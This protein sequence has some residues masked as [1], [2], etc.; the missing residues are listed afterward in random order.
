[1]SKKNYIDGVS[2]VIITYNGSERLLPTLTH[3]AHQK[4]IHFNFEIILIDNNSNDD[5]SEKAKK[6]WQ[7]LG[8]PFDFRVLLEATPGQMYARKRGVNEASY[9]YMLYCDD[10]NWLCENYASIAYDIVIKSD[11]IAA[12]GGKGIMEYEKDFIVPDWM[13]QYEKYFGTGAQGKQ[14]GDT[15]NDKGCLYTAGTLLDIKW[16]DKLYSMNFTPSLIGR[17]SKS[18]VGGE[19]TELTFALKLIGGKLY[20]SSK[21]TFKH[22]MP[23]SRINWEYLKKLFLGFGISDFCL[24][25]YYY[26]FEQKPFPNTISTFSSALKALLKSWLKKVR[27]KTKQGDQVELAYLK[28]KGIFIAVLLHYKKYLRS[29]QNI[30]LLTKF[31]KKI[32]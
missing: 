19:D 25:P 13:W 15:T 12:V 30:L 16:L 10:D 29:K 31:T 17:D 11:T 3:L 20:Y 4:N 28:K 1:M 23:A 6:I 32:D 9:R 27:S 8:A 2:L 18:L 24:S 26:I 5:T 7:E 21:M 14:D 22:F